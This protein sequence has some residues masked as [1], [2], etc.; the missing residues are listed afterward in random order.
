MI[1]S[2]LNQRVTFNLTTTVLSCGD[3]TLGEQK[4][5][6]SPPVRPFQYYTDIHDSHGLLDWISPM[7]TNREGVIQARYPANRSI[8]PSG[9]HDVLSTVVNF[10]LVVVVL[11]TQASV[12]FAF[13][14]SGASL[15]SKADPV[16]PVPKRNGM[17]AC[18]QPAANGHNDPNL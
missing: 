6:P 4:I 2:T 10:F 13:F 12:S 16:D 8:N 14:F 3:L 18:L 7:Y 11:T 1:K 9:Q 5:D 17:E 15:N